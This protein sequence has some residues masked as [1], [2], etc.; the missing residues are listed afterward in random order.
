MFKEEFELNEH[1]DTLNA[2]ARCYQSFDAQ[3]LD[4]FH[5]V[6]DN[7]WPQTPEEDLYLAENIHDF[8]VVNSGNGLA[9]HVPGSESP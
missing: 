9:T 1:L 3:T 4:K 5:T 8:T 6:F 2:L 7:S